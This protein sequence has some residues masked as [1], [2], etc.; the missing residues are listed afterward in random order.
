M[1]NLMGAY[2]GA[3]GTSTGANQENPCRL[4]PFLARDADL[5]EGQVAGVAE[6]LVAGEGS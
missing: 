6:Q 1:L 5:G 4:Q 3:E 2:F